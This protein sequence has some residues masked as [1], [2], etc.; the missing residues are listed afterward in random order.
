MPVFLSCAKA[1]YGKGFSRPCKLPRG[2][3]CGAPVNAS[4]ALRVLPDMPRA[5]VV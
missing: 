5:Q 2:D 1:Q 4:A 3:A